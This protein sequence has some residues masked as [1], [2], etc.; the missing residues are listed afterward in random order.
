MT[1]FDKVMELKIIRR[2]KSLLKNVLETLYKLN[3]DS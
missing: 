1:S 2:Q 3:F